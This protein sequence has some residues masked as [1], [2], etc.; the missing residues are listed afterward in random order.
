[1]AATKADLQEE[2]RHGRLRADFHHRIAVL[3]IAAPPL[4]EHRDD[5]PL[6][7]SHFLK[8]AA[9]RNGV[10]VP[11]VT[12]SALLEMSRHWRPGNVRELKNAIE[13]MVITARA[14]VAGPFAP[15]ENF[16]APRLLSSPATA[17]RLRD[18]LERTE[19]TCH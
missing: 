1:M 4:R 17:G 9:A 12:E 16:T 15:E 13:R 18:E 2:V 14:G 19:T 5:I 8:Q 6:L 11:Q 3:T 7:V 10:P